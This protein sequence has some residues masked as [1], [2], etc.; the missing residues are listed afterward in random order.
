MIICTK[1]L[2]NIPLCQLC[3]KVKMLFRKGGPKNLLNSV[4]KKKSII[5]W[6]VNQWVP[7]PT[8]SEMLITPQSQGYF[9]VKLD[10]ICNVNTEYKHHFYI[11]FL[12]NAFC[13]SL[14]R[15]PGKEW[16]RVCEARVRKRHNIQLY[17]EIELIPFGM[18][19]VQNLLEV[20]CLLYYLELF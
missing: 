14:N 8:F 12:E 6:S 7:H 2:I 4:L 16:G 17:A 15:N 19:D 20:F 1:G 11:F 13:S 9:K 3:L 5:N 10:D 18:Y